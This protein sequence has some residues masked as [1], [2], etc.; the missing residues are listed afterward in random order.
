VESLAKQ[1]TDGSDLFDNH[2]MKTNPSGPGSVTCA[3]A[4]AKS[5]NGKVILGW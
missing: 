4:L 1:A 2:S 5:D 3:L